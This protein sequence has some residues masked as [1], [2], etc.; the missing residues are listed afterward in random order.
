MAWMCSG[1]SGAWS[2]ARP[3]I[4]EGYGGTVVGR[5]IFLGSRGLLQFVEF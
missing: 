2:N 1:L 4:G 5:G 3:M